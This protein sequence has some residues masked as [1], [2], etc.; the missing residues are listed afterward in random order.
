MDS[1]RL[2]VR[3]HRYEA[4]RRDYAQSHI[5]GARY[6]HLDEDLAG[7]KTGVNGRHPLPD[8][9]KFSARLAGYG[10]SKD[11]QVVA[12]DASGGYYAARLWWML[13]WLGHPQGAVLDGGWKAW[14]DAGLP[15][16]GR[17]T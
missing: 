6:A 2:P 14:L 1:L 12:Y 5:A 10:L 16:T 17:V 4:G 7:S 15:V 13:R 8:P 9:E 11:M 3:P